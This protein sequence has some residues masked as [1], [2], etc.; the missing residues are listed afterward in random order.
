MTPLGFFTSVVL[1]QIAAA[2][3]GARVL[4]LGEAVQSALAKQPALRQAHATT[5]AFRARAD[6]TRAPLLPQVVG[7]A[8]YQRT[9]SNFTPRPG[10]NPNVLTGADQSQS[11]ATKNFFNF[12]IT[13]SQ[14]VWDFG[15]TSG[16]WRAAE[17]V[18]EGQE[19]SER[20]TRQ[21][22]ILNVRT[23]YFQAR[24]GKS[25]LE[26]AKE[27]LANQDRHLAQIQGFVDLGTRPGIDLAQA[28]A[29]RA[30]AELQVINAQN[31]YDG[32]KAQLNQAMGLELST[33]YDVADEAFPPIAGER[34]TVDRLLERALKARPDY[35][36]LNKTVEAQRLTVRAIK[37]AYGP[38]VGV[39]TGFTEAGVQL[40]NMAWNW[41]ATA[42]LTW[43]IFQGGL[44]KAQ[45]G[46]ANANLQALEAQADG[47]RLTIRLQIQQA[48]LAVTGAS[49]ALTASE[50]VVK[51][52][53]ERLVLAE[54]RYQTGVGSIIELG[55]AQVALTTALAQKVQAEYNLST[56]RA[57]LL[58]ALGQE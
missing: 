19:A 23:A 17:A 7:I 21:Q 28:R 39:S 35:Q 25:L 31:A 9:T 36:S 52:A 49:A 43:P 4:T 16:R 8:Q 33:A 58:G 54:G 14:L 1:M 50:E 37:G 34:E 10:S 42:T 29:D 55:D 41:N 18:A 38:T 46:E 6:E 22:T 12:G 27:T 2:N 45:V 11:F 47:L 51:N 3:G 53:K 44:T 24:A 5:N 15:Q 48:Q 20:Y 26:V 56:A 30:N 13:A 40:D 57:Q 32:G